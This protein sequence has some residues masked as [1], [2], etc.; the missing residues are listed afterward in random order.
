LR[1]DAELRNAG[2]LTR[3]VAG[4]VEREWVSETVRMSEERY[5]LAVKGAGV[6]IWDWDMERGTLYWSPLFK[7]MA[8]LSP[9][10]E[11]VTHDTF[12]NL[13]HPD[14]RGLVENALRNHLFKRVPYDTEFRFSLPD[15]TVRWFRGR[16][17]AVWN[18]DGRAIR[19]AGSI[20]DITDQILASQQLQDSKARFLDF[21]DAASEWFWESDIEHRYTYFSERLSEHAGVVPSAWLHLSR[22]DLAAEAM[23]LP[24]WRQHVA[25]LNAHRPFRNFEYEARGPNHETLWFRT[26]G[27]PVFDGVGGFLG[28]RGTGTN[29]TT[30]KLTEIAHRRSEA[31]A[32]RAEQILLDAIESLSDGFILLDANRCFLMCNSQ[33]RRMFPAVASILTP[34]A[35]YESICRYFAA[36]RRFSDEWDQDTWVSRRLEPVGDGRS[37]EEQLSDGRWVR[38]SDFPTKDGGVAGL[39][40]DITKAKLQEQKLAKRERELLEAQKIARIGHWRLEVLTGEHEWSAGLYQIMKAPPGDYQPT[41]EDI[42]SRIHEQDRDEAARRLAHCVA[43]GSTTQWE[44]RI[45]NHEGDLMIW[46]SEGYCEFGADGS[47][48][49]VFGICRDVTNE[50]QAEDM[51]RMAKDAAEAASKAKS[52]FLA[53]MSHELRTPLN[54]IIGFSD[55]LSLEMLGPLGQRYL[56]YAQDINRSGRH[57]LELINDLLDM[58]RIEAG[59]VVLHEEP[60]ALDQV[61]DEALL[62]SR[63]VTSGTRHSIELDIPSPTPV[64]RVDRRSLKQ[65]LIN[66]LGNA[67][68]FTPDGG[69]IA[70]TARVS[71]D[72]VAIVVTDSG[73]GIPRE[74]ID[75]LGKPFSQV[76]SGMARRHGGSGMGVFISKALVERHGGKLGIDSSLG[77]GTTVTIKLPLDRLMA[78]SGS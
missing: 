16:A 6:G 22:M 15:G 35:S 12:E 48:T 33:Y 42:L 65:V 77:N 76:E 1:N 72:G 67:V 69:R 24:H 56:E 58:A 71:S 50:R 44:Y 74:R 27:K 13:L 73:I 25:T 63:P 39:R 31:R 38:I 40:T 52:D 64:L 53:N 66:L 41:M 10:E 57:L 62:L 45:H 9:E 2:R 36:N 51:L 17:Q 29:I 46:Q 59:K 61:I 8:G 55:M 68:K 78:C 18:A 37:Q 60:V 11:P 14:D 5:A 75:D 20:Y 47:V 3:L 26:S 21:A 49:S 23:E 28:Y 7:E 19:I 32:V 70:V 34:G 43:T 54:A 30:Q 4:S